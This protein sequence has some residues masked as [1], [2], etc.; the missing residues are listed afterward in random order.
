MK[1]HI[2]SIPDEVLRT[3]TNYHWPGSIRELQNV[4][5]RAVILSSGNVL[6]APV[7][8]RKPVAKTAASNATL[9]DAERY[10]ILQALHETDWVIGGANGAAARLGV[11]RTTLLLQNEASAYLTSDRE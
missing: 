1:K 6:S 3:L 5:E 9:E 7:C 4:I 2:E 10:H 8:D 11:R